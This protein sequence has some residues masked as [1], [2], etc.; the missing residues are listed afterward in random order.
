L[1]VDDRPY[2][3]LAGELH[4]SS[5]SSIRYMEPVWNKL[6]ALNLNTVIGTVSWELLEPEEGRFDFRLVDAQI[7]EA[8]RRNM[9][10]VLIWFATWKNGASTYVPAWVKT[11]PQRFP[12][13]KVNRRPDA[14]PFIGE[15]LETLSPLGEASLAA[16]ANAFRAL[17]R[18]IKEVDPHRTVIMMQV[19]N[20]PGLLG[21]SRDRSPL[22]EAAWSKPVPGELLNYLAKNRA[23]LLPEI[24][25]VWGA[26]GYRTSGTWAEV[27][28]QDP[29]AD[30]VFMAWHIG[31]YIGKV[32][33]AGKAEL[34][35]PMFANAWLG[36]QPKMELPGEYPSGGPVAR[37][38]DVWRA[39]APAIDLLAPDI[40]VDDFKGV[41]ALYSR[42]GNPLLIP[43][44]RAIVGNLFWAIGQHSALAFSPF[45]IEDLPVDHQLADAYRALRPLIPLIAQYQAE[46]KVIGALIEEGSKADTSFGGYKLTFGTT[47]RFP[48]LL[49]PGQQPVDPNAPKLA[50]ATPFGPR[51]PDTRPFGLIVNTGTDEFL[52]VG[53]G[54]TVEFTPESPG[55]PRAGFA[56]IDELTYEGGRW[57]QG[58]R[59]NGDE[60]RAALRGGR[61][62][63]LRV[64]VYRHD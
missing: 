46:G 8:R 5:A 60:G 15:G 25:E 21:D 35:L 10:L 20:E 19:E 24:R 3:M 23:S 62:G 54:L 49:A 18:H 42:S 47:R 12:R 48:W 44:A 6:R 29:H 51:P 52:I 26:N 40:Y 39:A 28:G 63:V 2:L 43:E 9:R 22:A 14:R 38:L 64:K 53:S 56:A 31:R 57:I 41:C 37:V 30:E 16:D 59:L 36:P 61:V 13:M 17:M 45:G 4:N 11:D 33:Q 58:R 32:A 7:Q 50:P 34:A 1:I 27:F 55:P